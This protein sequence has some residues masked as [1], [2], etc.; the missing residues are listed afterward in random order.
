MDALG[1]SVNNIVNAQISSG[2]A[3]ADTKLATISTAGKVNTT[4]LVTTS[5]AQGDILYASSASAWTRLGY[6]TSG[7]S[8]I[9]GGAA[10]NPA[11][12]T[13]ASLSTA[14]GSAPSYSARA[15][16][17]FN[18]TGTAAITASGNVASITDHNTGT[19][20]LTYTTAIEDAN[21]AV[22]GGC[23]ALNH[24]SWLTFDQSVPPAVGSVRFAVVSNDNY[25]PKDPDWCSIIVMR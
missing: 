6:G 22:A 21:Y 20:T 9:T 11:W 18:G 14:S 24:A 25:A 13:P 1:S 4:A 16:A 3:I 7:Q 15:W 12:G 23:A 19:Y 2:A 17:A 5:Q 8:L 10:A